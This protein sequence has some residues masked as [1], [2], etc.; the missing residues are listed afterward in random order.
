MKAPFVCRAR[1]NIA[2]ELQQE[3]N[4]NNINESKWGWTNF[5]FREAMYQAFEDTKLKHDMSQAEKKRNF[6]GKVSGP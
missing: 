3:H 4:N 6:V 5:F 1:H 2:V